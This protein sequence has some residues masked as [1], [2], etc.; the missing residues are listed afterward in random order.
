M[1]DEEDIGL[2]PQLFLGGAS[3][4][5][6]RR[7]RRRRPPRR[8]RPRPRACGTAARAATAGCRPRPAGMRAPARSPRSSGCGRRLQRPPATWRWPPASGSGGGVKASGEKKGLD[9]SGNGACP[10]EWLRV[11]FNALRFALDMPP[12]IRRGCLLVLAVWSLSVLP[13]MEIGN[14]L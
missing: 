9:A 4:S 5:L 13:P 6:P 12:K 14:R 2:L 3:A 11:C 7:A 8:R 1:V 10:S